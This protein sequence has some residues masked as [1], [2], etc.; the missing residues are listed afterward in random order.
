M[1]SYI[2]LKSQYIVEVIPI[3]NYIIK[4]LAAVLPFLISPL[5]IFINDVTLSV[6]YTFFTNDITSFI[7]CADYKLGKHIFQEIVDK[8]LLWSRNNSLLFSTIKSSA[9]HFG[10]CSHQLHVQ[11]NN[12]LITPSNT[13]AIWKSTMKHFEKISYFLP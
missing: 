10:S 6:Q 5:T 3:P 11:L 4:K 9:L 7:S 2:F 12:S 1:D 8:L 13:Q